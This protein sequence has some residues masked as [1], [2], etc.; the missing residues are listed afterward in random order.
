MFEKN[1]TDPTVKCYFP[2][3]VVFQELITNYDLFILSF[4][5]LYFFLPWPT[6]T[7]VIFPPLPHLSSLLCQHLRVKDASLESVRLGSGTRPTGSPLLSLWGAC[8]VSDQWMMGWLLS[9]LLLVLSCQ[10]DTIPGSTGFGVRQPGFLHWLCLS[11][12]QSFI[13]KL[14]SE[15]VMRQWTTHINVVNQMPN[16]LG[17]SVVAS[18]LFRLLFQSHILDAS[19]AVLSMIFVSQYL[20]KPAPSWGL[21]ELLNAIWVLPVY[22]KASLLFC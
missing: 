11:D 4:L 21:V 14:S 10:S 17:P 12:H 15:I 9:V 6:W 19:R 22:K 18:F 7:V 13:C 20:R 5:L 2:L 16:T 8:V 1:L 3:K